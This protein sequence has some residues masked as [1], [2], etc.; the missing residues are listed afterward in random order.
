MKKRPYDSILSMNK[1]ASDKPS[2]QSE[3]KLQ[4]ETI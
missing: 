2:F 4:N 1:E 3:I